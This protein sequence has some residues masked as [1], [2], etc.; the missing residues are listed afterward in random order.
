MTGGKIFKKVIGHQQAKEILHRSI[1][2]EKIAQAY[3]FGGEK[4]LGKQLLALEF[5]KGVNCTHRK[6]GDGKTPANFGFS[7]PCQECRSCRLIDSSAHPDI[8]LIQPEGNTLKVNQIRNLQQKIFLKPQMGERKF[9]ILND[10]EKMNREAANCFLKTLEE[11]PKNC[12]LILISSSPHLLLTTLASRCV[13]VVFAPFTFDFLV[14][15]LVT[16]I[17]ISPDQALDIA[18]FSM[19]RIGKA[20]TIQPDSFFEEKRETLQFLT[21]FSEGGISL[22]LKTA[23]IW[24]RDNDVMEEKM[25]WLLLWLRE[26]LLIQMGSPLQLVK[27]AREITIMKDLSKI[28]SIDQIHC[29][30]QEL[31]QAK[32]GILRNHNRQLCME[33]ILLLLREIIAE[34]H[35]VAT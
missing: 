7:D 10:A 28:F 21:S 16:Q 20:L 22:I 12:T 2:Q 18:Y 13:K 32:E 24:S 26:I 31:I 29:L 4:A 34:N 27:E 15:V 5:A 30:H 3:L 8:H 9:F 33:K 35:M 17:G 19:G 14:D 11:P 1:L 6:K 23:E 25:L